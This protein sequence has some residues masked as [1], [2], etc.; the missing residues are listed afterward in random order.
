MGSLTASEPPTAA[1]LTTQELYR[2]LLL[3]IGERAAT[4]EPIVPAAQGA[5]QEAVMA[6]QTM[7]SEEPRPGYH[8][9]TCPYAAGAC[10]SA[11]PAFNGT[12]F[13]SSV[14]LR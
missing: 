11:A 9:R 13:T 10:D 14:V 8:C 6:A 3:R 2:E 5:L 4:L 12:S 7:E 1:A